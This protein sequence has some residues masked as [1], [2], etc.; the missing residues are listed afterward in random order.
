MYFYPEAQYKYDS[1]G[2]IIS[3]TFA[4]IDDVNE[5]KW[6]T[7]NSYEYDKNRI[8]KVQIPGGTKAE[9][10]FYDDGKLK[11][12]TYPALSDGS[13][14]KSEYTYDG[15]SRLKTLV[16]KKGTSVLSSYS[17]TYDSNGN[18]LTANE[19]VGNNTNNTTYSYDK[20][21][22]ITSVIGTKNADSYYEYDY[23]GNRK[24]NFEQT[25]FLSENSAS[26]R[27][28]MLE[29]MCYSKTGNN[30]TVI[31][32]GTNGY[33]YVK[34]ENSELPEYYIYDQQ[35]RL[36][37]EVTFVNATV[38]DTKQIIMYPKYQYIWGPD[39]VLAQFDVLNNA[40]YYYLYNGHGDVIQIV[41]TDG[42]IV[43]SYDYDVWGNFISKDETIHN[44]FTYFG[45]TYDEAT[46][47]YY[48][49]ARYY[50]PTT[51]R[52]TQQDSAEDGYNWYVYGNQNPVLYVDP[53]GEIAVA[54][55]AAIIIIAGAAAAASIIYMAEHRKKGTTN[56]AN[57]AKHERGQKR[58][59]DDS[60]GGEKGDARR[61][62]RKDKRKR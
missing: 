17:Y 53:T 33:R 48:L 55:D 60:F 61:T 45:Q 1:Y 35:G 50:D 2:N 14:L 28:D 7:S 57:R 47:L 16:N 38:N 62:P 10:T 6:V 19:S 25:D 20:L 44:P 34:R 27:Y 26:Y 42:N 32:Y 23:R 37:T 18:I 40:T 9:Y 49:R 51:G 46:G 24:V 4:C 56:P 3:S 30:T 43:N 41:D 15:L 54:D 31:K 8:S 11:S 5:K 21:N 39:K 52:F 12:V 13:I 59:Q 36:Q 22:R 58:K 29:N